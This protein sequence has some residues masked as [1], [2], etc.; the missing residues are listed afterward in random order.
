MED[1]HARI[2]S[3]LATSKK[4]LMIKEIAHNS[5]LHPQTVARNLDVLEVLGRVRKIQIGH[6]KKYYLTNSIMISSFIDI[7]SDL[8]IILNSTHHIQYINNAAEKF[9]QLNSHPVIGE[10]LDLL[11]LDLFSSPQILEGL[12][13][14]KPDKIFR[15]T[16]SHNHE[17]NR[18]WYSISII[19]LALKT[20]ETSIAIIA[21]DITAEKNAE[22]LLK[23]NEEK[24]R[25]ISENIG[26]VVWAYDRLSKKL[27]YISPSVYQL[28]GYTPEELFLLPDV[29][30]VTTPSSVQLIRNT[31]EELSP[32]PEGQKSLVRLL[33]ITHI[34]KNGSLVEVEM[35]M[36]IL[37]D[38][39]GEVSR[40]LCV[41]RNISDRIRFEEDMKK[42]Q[43]HAE[44]LACILKRSSQP[45]VLADSE[46]NITFWNKAFED[47]IGYSPI[48]I[49]TMNWIR[50][51]TPKE[52]IIPEQNSLAEL[53]IPDQSVRYEKEYLRKDGS[54]VHV[55]L[56][57]HLL[58]NN[59]NSKCSYYSFITDI[60]ERN[61]PKNDETTYD[62]L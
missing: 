7:S 54:R 50:D 15:T 1:A 49:Q 3:T 29:E 13:Q 17:G 26:D 55:E 62:Q 8:I 16:I 27:I 4:S 43:N 42:I 30:K 38:S 31:Y 34:H 57:T 35:V 24:F 58:I 5:G 20:N 59:Y 28:L 22:D 41:T 18:L 37:F 25:L 19:S 53:H 61:T 6:A 11:N 40:I 44:D 12:K 48:E 39:S 52:W 10:R 45:F 33:P 47:L 2:I 21:E 32:H 60:S 46:G 51:L 23:E 9:L 14:Y 36:T 56:N